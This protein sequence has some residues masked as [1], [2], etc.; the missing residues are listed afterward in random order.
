MLRALLNFFLIGGLLFGAK[1][2]YEGRR[3][4]GPEISVKVAAGATPAEV[5]AAIR[6][7]ILLN[8]ARR[9]GWDKRD[10]IVFT[11]LVRNMR[12]IDPDSTE[13]DLT[14]YQRALEMNMQAHD[15]VVRAR[16]LYRAGESL[17]YVP[18]DRMPTRDQL[19]AHRQ[20][21]G[22]RF[23]REGRVRFHHVF[24]SRS[25]RGDALP[26][27]ASAMREQLSSLGDG[28]PKGLG[29]PLPGLRMEQSAT[30][31]K[32][33]EDF[34]AELARVVDGAVTGVWRGPAGSVYGLHF[35]R[36]IDQDPAYVPS[37]DVIAAE[38]RAD[39]L[40]E[41]RDELRAERMNALRGAYTVHI[42][43]VP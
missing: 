13:G 6:D 38:V 42:E 36:V 28:P 14:L 35:V 23:E 39:R 34:G 20:A 1:A 5:E 29:D 18:E 17:A 32:V 40:R 8:E 16:L 4:E 19:E 10:P 31:S 26:A 33:K 27:D 9:Y 12:F 43:R 30:P 2:V 22:D 7:A 21:H 3:V 37:L 11:H 25:K 41:I 15:P 24:L